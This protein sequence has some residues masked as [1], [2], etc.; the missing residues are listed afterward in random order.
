M[1][2]AYRGWQET[3]KW[4][5]RIAPIRRAA[6][7]EVVLA[8][9]APELA[10]P[11][12]ALR[13]LRD[14][15]AQR[16]FACVG[17]T[18]GFARLAERLPEDCRDVIEDADLLLQH[19]FDLL[20][21]RQLWFGRP[22]DWHL[23]PLLA[24]RTPL[25]HW[26]RLDP[27]DSSVVGDSKVVWELNRHQWLVRL[28]QARVLTGDE[29]YAEACLAAIDDWLDANPP[30]HGINWASSLEV[31]YRLISWCWVLHLLR[32]SPALS[33]ER[34]M[35]ILAAVY[36]HAT[37]VRRYLSYYF[38]PNTHLTGEALGLFYAGTL[39]PEFLDA[40]RWRDL[41]TRI[42][43]SESHRQICRDGVHFERSTC[44]HRYTV[45]IY[46]HFLL[47]AA[48][49][50]ITVPRQVVESAK[51]MVEFLVHVRRPNGS[52]PEIGDADGGSLLPLTPRTPGDARGVFAIAAT[53][54]ERPDFAWAAEGLRPE[55]VW[56][57]GADGVRTF[58]AVQPAEPVSIIPSRVF[59]TGGY[60][61]MRNG[62][63]HDAHQLIVDVGPLGDPGSSGHG[64]ADL[65]SIQCAIFGE[66]CLVD[67]GTYCYTGQPKWRD[68]FRA[69]GAH[70]TVIVDG[71][72]Q[73]EP[74][75]P[76]GWH[77]QPRARVREWHSNDEFDYLDADHDAYLGL[78][79]PVSH[80]RRVIF[81]KP[82]YWIAIDDLLG[83]SRHQLDLIF[84]FAPIQ[85][86][87]G[88]HPWARAETAGGHVLWVSSFPSAPVEAS[89]RCGEVSPIRGWH[90]PDY[91]QRVPAPLLVY[92]CAVALPWRMVTLLLPDRQGLSQPPSVK[93]ILDEAGVPTGLAFER[94]HQSVRFDDLAIVAERG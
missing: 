44:Y 89:L 15:A 86:T 16:F 92:S 17:D 84:Q 80:R 34:L 83:T 85:V 11:I 55:V 30:D 91:G 66:P 10:D 40:P 27:L 35:R 49:N 31:A 1:E 64:H 94:S 82:H 73:S 46:L 42:L 90:S 69:T 38:S 3:S 9:H 79:D 57:Q 25:E 54:F 22:I 26:S 48:R 63:D 70:S 52:I 50:G 67:A 78:P 12:S 77:R 2:V 13:T 32:H 21:Y 29:R 47:L 72:C 56:L 76:F 20:G 62:W 19:R 60:A 51:Q 65:L 33:G 36:L 8:E 24:R 74:A 59:P 4:L 87:L 43:V 81:V 14:H 39:F 61:V 45:D 58:D 28:A 6:D 68:F 41:G 5:D 53:L 23:D 71:Q 37:H 7:V 88:P 75:S 93:P 18:E